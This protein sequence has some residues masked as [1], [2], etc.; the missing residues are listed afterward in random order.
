MRFCISVYLMLS[1]T[2]WLQ[3]ARILTPINC[4][5]STVD[6][7]IVLGEGTNGIVYLEHACTRYRMF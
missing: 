2:F 5:N 3:S 4:K 1:A 7:D 6:Q